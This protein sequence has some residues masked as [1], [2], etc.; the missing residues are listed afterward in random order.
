MRL[1]FIKFYTSEFL[2]TGWYYG[3]KCKDDPNVIAMCIISYQQCTEFCVFQETN[4]FTHAEAMKLVILGKNC[5]ACK[6]SNKKVSSN[7]SEWN[8]DK[9]NEGRKLHYV[10]AN[11]KDQ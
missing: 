7:Q 9:T 11:I 2:A 1:K 8:F 10:K 6:P 4:R 3:E 5:R